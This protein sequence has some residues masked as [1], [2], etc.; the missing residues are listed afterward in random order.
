MNPTMDAIYILSPEP[1]IVD[2]LLADF[3]RRRYRKTYLVWTTVLDPQLRRRL[4]SSQTA[5]Q[6]IAGDNP[7]T[8]RRR[9]HHAETLDIQAS[10]LYP[11]TSF[12]ANHI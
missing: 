11:S 7:A 8:S 4:D 9:A 12:P 10:K 5:Q 6:Q 3:E 2:C 1:H